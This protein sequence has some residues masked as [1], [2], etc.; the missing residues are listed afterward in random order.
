MQSKGKLRPIIVLTK[1]ISRTF[2]FRG[3]HPLLMT[4]IAILEDIGG[5]FTPG[6]DLSPVKLRRSIDRAETFSSPSCHL[7]FAVQDM[8]SSF[9]LTK[10]TKNSSSDEFRTNFWL[11]SL[12]ILPFLPQAAYARYPLFYFGLFWFVSWTEN[13]VINKGSKNSPIKTWKTKQSA[14]QENQ[15]FKL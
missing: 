4:E 2:F 13:F 8:T 10:K 15:K 14:D 12:A 6:K 1:V 11:F 3:K 5:N 9:N 7:N